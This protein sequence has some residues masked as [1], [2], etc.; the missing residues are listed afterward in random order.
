MPTMGI[1]HLIINWSI[2]QTCV[3]LWRNPILPDPGVFLSQLHFMSPCPKQIA[4]MLRVDEKCSETWI[5]YFFV[6]PEEQ[7]RYSSLITLKLI[8]GLKGIMEIKTVVS[9]QGT[10][11]APPESYL[12]WI[13]MLI[14]TDGDDYTLC[15]EFNSFW[16]CSQ[17]SLE[18]CF[19]SIH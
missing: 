19:A 4:A 10:S 15:C 13:L 8:I 1:S 6:P 12:N 7:S 16:R 9:K 17:L 11:T 18:H 2:V 3:T 5:S 14:S